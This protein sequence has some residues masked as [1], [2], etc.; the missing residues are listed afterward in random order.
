MSPFHTL[1]PTPEQHESD[2]EVNKEAR[3]ED[4]REIPFESDV[5]DIQQD[6]VEAL[7]REKN[8]L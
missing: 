1:V 3:Q 6:P 5:E 8:E 2:I 7:E 4:A